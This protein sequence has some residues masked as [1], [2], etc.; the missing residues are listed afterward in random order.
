MKNVRLHENMLVITLKMEKPWESA[1]GKSSLVASTHGVKQTDIT[2]QGQSVHVV[3]S[4]FF[5]KPRK[6][7]R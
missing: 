3:A 4:A 7:F 1:S 5:Y 2:V 6:K